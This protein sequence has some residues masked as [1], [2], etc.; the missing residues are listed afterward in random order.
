MTNLSN[1]QIMFEIEKIYK[2]RKEAE[3]LTIT[4][5][6]RDLSITRTKLF[7]AIRHRLASRKTINLFRDYLEKL[8]KE[9]LICGEGR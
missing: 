7:N 3:G 5:F 2:R 4:S 6:A 8:N 9:D 1:N